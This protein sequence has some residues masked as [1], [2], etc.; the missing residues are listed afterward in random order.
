MTLDTKDKGVFPG[1]LETY[2]P[3]VKSFTYYY[4]SNSGVMYNSASAKIL[5]TLWIVLL[6]K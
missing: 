6:L 4:V 5:T 2:T 3:V 1:K